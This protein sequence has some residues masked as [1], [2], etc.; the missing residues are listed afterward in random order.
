MCNAARDIAVIS[1]Y[2][3]LIFINEFFS[4]NI[5][6]NNKDQKDHN[7]NFIIFFDVVCVEREIAKKDIAKNEKSSASHQKGV[8]NVSLAIEVWLKNSNGV[9]KQCIK[10]SKLAIAPKIS[11]FVDIAP[12]TSQLIKKPKIVI[13]Y[14]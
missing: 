6:T 4:F 5:N 11:G 1:A 3:P 14:N 7:K 13:F 12:I 9:A 10:H 8:N 2:N